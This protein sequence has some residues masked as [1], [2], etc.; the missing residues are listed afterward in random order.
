LHATFDG[1]QRGVIVVESIWP[2]PHSKAASASIRSS[3]LIRRAE[4]WRGVSRQRGLG[5][6]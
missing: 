6:A 2:T 4:W 5:E 1:L 3:A